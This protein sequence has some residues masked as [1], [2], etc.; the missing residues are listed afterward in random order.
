MDEKL[1]TDKKGKSSWPGGF[2]RGDKE[3]WG[4]LVRWLNERS[5]ITVPLFPSR[6][7]PLS[8]LTFKLEKQS[9]NELDN[10][11]IKKKALLSECSVSKSKILACA[12]FPHLISSW[13]GEQLE[14][15]K[16]DYKSWTQAHP[17]CS[18]QTYNGALYQTKGRGWQRTANLGH[19]QIGTQVCMKEFYI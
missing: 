18:R 14:T 13:A 17:H 15:L 1:N 11:L 10:K 6:Y 9:Q 19:A 2:F 3:E 12:F 7:I 4:L 5:T 8:P 16:S